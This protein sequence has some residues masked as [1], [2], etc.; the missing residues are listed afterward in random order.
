MSDEVAPGTGAGAGGDGRLQESKEAIDDAREA[1]RGALDDVEPEMDF[2]DAG[3]G[4][5]SQDS[6][7]PRPN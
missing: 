1:A 4:P 7:I 6:A 3:K 5:G 2:P